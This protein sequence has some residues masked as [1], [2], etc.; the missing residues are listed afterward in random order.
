[1][2][3]RGPHQGIEVSS[4]RVS[5]Q[6][7]LRGARNQIRDNRK[8]LM[9]MKFH[10]KMWKRFFTVWVTELEQIAQRDYEVCLTGDTKNHLD[11]PMFNVL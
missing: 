1:M 6:A 7:F 2:S 8:I 10:L 11:K 9:H 4:G 3:E 5:S